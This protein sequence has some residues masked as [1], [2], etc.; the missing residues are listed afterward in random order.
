MEGG[1]FIRPFLCFTLLFCHDIV[2]KNIIREEGYTVS[3]NNALTK[4]HLIGYALGDMG[5]CM[6]FSIV[7]SFMT[8]YYINVTMLDTA[9][10]AM[11]TLV[12][13]IWDAAGNP[14]IGML[15]DREYAHTRN[16]RGKFRPWMLRSAP[17]LTIAA[18]LMVTA[19]TWVDGAGKLVVVFVTYLL[20]ETFYTMFNLPYASLLSAMAGNDEE[21]AALS[22]VRGVGAM[23]GNLLPTTLF[24]LIIEKFSHNPQLGYAG[25]VTLCA[26]LGLIACLLSCRFTQERCMVSTSED[27]GLKLSDIGV[28]FRKNK[29]F[30]ALCIHAVCQCVLM[31]V[32][33]TMGT[34]IYSDILGSIT[35]MSLGMMLS[36]PV[37]LLVL[38]IAPKLTRKFG[39]E[40][41]IRTGLLVGML[42]HILLFM[43]HIT[44]FVN[45]WVHMALNVLGSGSI[46]VSTM[47]QWGLVSET[48]N[49]NA[50]LTGKRTE[51][52]IFG[53][54]NMLRRVGQAIGSALSVATLGWVGYDVALAN[55]GLQQ[56]STTLFGMKVIC[57]LVPAIFILGSW[58]A[59]RFLWN[60]TPEEK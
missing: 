3:K 44:T 21:R 50:Y 26:L 1:G 59:F 25:G 40:R 4:K 16:P 24:P 42:I 11:M 15:M 12:W 38:T 56:S 48:V 46:G 33:M 37:N 7:G 30:Q 53:V 39:L 29:A 23:L 47:M 22:S 41:L 36:M 17:L 27:S 58:A 45:V 54:F 19:P 6:T 31:G 18:I 2:I 57:F 34:Y 52:T 20:Y 8:R 43:L 35:Y 32:N 10:L 51:G 13:K 14:V 49:Y 28:T 5:G 9:V 60:I 55:Q